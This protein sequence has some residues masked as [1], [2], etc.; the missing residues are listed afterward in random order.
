MSRQILADTS[1]RRFVGSAAALGLS[2]PSVRWRQPTRKAY[3]S[4]P[5]TGCVG[6]DRAA[7]L[8]IAARR[9]AMA[10]EAAPAV[11]INGT[12][13]GPLPTSRE[14]ARRS[15]CA[16]STVSTKTRPSTGTACWCRPTKTASPASA[17]G[18]RAGETFTYRV[19]RAA[20]G[21]LPVTT[22]TPRS[23]SRL[24]TTRR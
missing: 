13:P 22:A 23:R 18:I 19:P 20:N 9:S 7:E 15:R 11:T 21:H 1:R 8:V 10:A 24:A 4:R 3:W 5:R 2:T 14:G 17:P 6:G 16:S 12:V